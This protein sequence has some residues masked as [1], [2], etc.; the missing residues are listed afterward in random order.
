MRRNACAS[1]DAAALVH[2]FNEADLD[3]DG[4][5]EFGEMERF[6]KSKIKP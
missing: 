2:A 4:S 6:L 1:V 3:S 5:I